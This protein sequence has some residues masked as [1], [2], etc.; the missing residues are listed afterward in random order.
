MGIQAPT[1]WHRITEATNKEAEP[2]AMPRVLEAWP[3]PTMYRLKQGRERGLKRALGWTLVDLDFQHASLQCRGQ[4]GVCLNN[5]IV[6]AR[7]GEC[8]YIQIQI[9]VAI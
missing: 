7:R 1:K 4:F 3:E 2:P 9:A 8:L 5:F 6:R